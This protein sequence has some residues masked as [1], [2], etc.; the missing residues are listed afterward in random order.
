MS[1][2]SP[3]SAI[4]AFG[5]A[6]ALAAYSADQA[7]PAAQAGL[8]FDAA[9]IKPAAVD[10]KG[11]PAQIKPRAV[12]PQRFRALSQAESLIEW[13]YDI[14]DFQITGGPVWIRDGSVRFDIEATAAKPSSEPEMKRRLQTLLAERFRLQWHPESRE[15]AVYAL[16][17]AKS[18]PKLAPAKAEPRNGGE[19]TIDIGK[20]E[21]IARAIAMGSL[22]QIL[23]ENMGRPVIDQTGLT[24]RYDLDL[25]YDPGSLIDWRLEP[26]I[27]SLLQ[28]LGLRIESR[29]AEIKLLAIDAIERPAAN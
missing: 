28:E 19:G 5:A 24:G 14:R 15:T 8:E 20:G 2:I 7:H 26:V 29:R 22:V 23:T 16:L 12:N 10:A 3:I 21:F 4:L 1:R 27:P 6:G 18:G 25:R 17:A 11:F 13:A 9:S